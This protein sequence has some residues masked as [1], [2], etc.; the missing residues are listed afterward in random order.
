MFSVGISRHGFS[1]GIQGFLNLEWILY[2]AIW[3][4]TGIWDDTSL[5]LD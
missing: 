5:W 4:D 3:D 2:T 1:I